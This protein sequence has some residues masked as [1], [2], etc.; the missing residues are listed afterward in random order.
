M[1]SPR[2]ESTI[3]GLLSSLRSYRQRHDDI[4]NPWPQIP[5]LPLLSLSSQQEVEATSLVVSSRLGVN[6]C[7][8]PT[9]SVCLSFSY[10][11]MENAETK[12][13]SAS[14]DDFVDAALSEDEL[15]EVAL[16]EAALLKAHVQE[17]VLPRSL[18]ARSRVRLSPLVEEAA[19]LCAQVDELLG[20]LRH[21]APD[22]TASPD[23]GHEMEGRDEEEQDDGLSDMDEELSHGAVEGT[24]LQSSS[25]RIASARPDSGLEAQLL[26]SRCRQWPLRPYDPSRYCSSASAHPKGTA[27]SVWT[28]YGPPVRKSLEDEE[29]SLLFRGRLLSCARQVD[30]RRRQHTNSRLE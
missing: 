24:G 20:S 27:D 4:G 16:Q 13:G 26:Q 29:R 18:G 10:S 23:A 17:T 1:T 15:A 11:T 9:D 30:E 8:Q 12:M 19:R 2:S 22:Q 6:A 25:P 28:T 3:D 7:D 14:G 5:A 21:K